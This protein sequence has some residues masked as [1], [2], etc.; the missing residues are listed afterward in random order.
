MKPL[1]LKFTVALFLGLSLTLT[2]LGLMIYFR[3][4]WST[5]HAAGPHHVAL[6]CTGV[7]APCYTTVQAAVD[8]AAP[9]EIIKVAAG[10]YTGVSF[11]AS[12]TQVVYI[13]KSVTI[14]GGYTHAFTEPPDPQANPTTLDAQGQGQ[15]IYITGK[16]SPTIEGLRITGGRGTVKGGSLGSYGGG[17]FVSEATA[18]ISNNHIFSNSVGSDGFGGGVFLGSDQSILNA[19]IITG[20][21]AGQGGGGLT[22]VG[23]KATLNRNTI[24]HNKACYGGGLDIL[25]SDKGITLNGNIIANNTADDTLYHSCW[26][27]FSVGGGLILDFGSDATLINNLI[28]DNHLNRQA[29][30]LGSG[31][32]IRA[33]SPQFLHNT[34]AHN[35]G[36]DG[37][38]I[39]ITEYTDFISGTVYSSPRLTNTIL[40]SQTV[41]VT[42]TAGNTATLNSTLWHG[43]TINWSGAGTVS[44]SNN[45]TGNPAFVNPSSGN[46]HLG[47]TSAAIDKGLNAGIIMDIDNQHRPQGAGFDLGADEYPS[48]PI[49]LLSIGKS[50]PATAASGSL[51]TY[52]LIITNSGLASATNLVITD[53][54]PAGAIYVSGGIRV[55]NVVSWT[56]PN[57]TANGGV[58]Q[59]TF[60]VTASETIT[61]NDY[62]VQAD[63]GSS[64]QGS[65]TVI[66]VIHDAQE[67]EQKLFLPLI[68]KQ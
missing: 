32:Y 14:R 5:T 59:T 22:M 38:A 53:A 30:S 20:N 64:A 58:T 27:N 37:S 48:P 7:P 67:P 34:I 65:I 2:L 6:N 51:I 66:T 63:N 8:A 29:N 56:M 68:L 49:P 60:V 16:I 62:R 36:G 39:F 42:A 47:P 12:V 28:T 3:L 43:N 50:G 23:S 17:I 9:G 21:S 55:G 11:R 1:L 52:T 57:L 10:T 19:N 44:A 18:L 4:T 35:T 25:Y 13:S 54:I 40:V 41:G 31:I 26:G 45:Y 33:S 46:Y 24:T 61:N 15:V